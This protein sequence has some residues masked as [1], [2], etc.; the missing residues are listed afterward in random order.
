MATPAVSPESHIVD[1]GI[2][3]DLGPDSVSAPSGGVHP[4]SA[5]TLKPQPTHTV[6]PTEP[7]DIGDGGEWTPEERSYLR[8]QMRKQILSDQNAE[9]AGKWLAEHRD[10]YLP[11][12]SNFNLIA[13]I[14][15][16]QTGE[17]VTPNTEFNPEIWS[18]ALKFA[19]VHDM[20]EMPPVESTSEA[21]VQD[22]K[23]ARIK[24]EFQNEQPEPQPRP[25]IQTGMSETCLAP[26]EGYESDTGQLD[27]ARVSHDISGLPL[28]QARAKMEQLMRAASGGGNDWRLNAQAATARRQA[29]Y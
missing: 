12:N 3:D 14:I 18:A 28:D 21:H 4:S 2:L 24:A 13:S 9:A 25:R 22:R 7:N 17:P 5:P 15:K 10:E 19:L 6:Q 23:L 8:A 27:L 11:N 20:L 29:G 26:A 16:E 1:S